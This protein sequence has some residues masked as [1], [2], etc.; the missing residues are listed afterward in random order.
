MACETKLILGT[1]NFFRPY[2]L[3]GQ[4][5]EI[6]KIIETA[7]DVGVK[8][9]DM[10]TAYIDP[11]AYPIKFIKPIGKIESLLH[12][13]NRDRELA[14]GFIKIHERQWDG[15]SVDTAAE[16]VKAAKMKMKCIEFPYNVF[17]HDKAKLFKL[18]RKRKITTIARSVF[19]QG[20]LLMDDPPI[21]LEYVKRFEHII[22]PY[23]ISK[24]EAAFLF[25]YCHGGINYVVVGVNTVEQLK[26]LSH[27]T[28]YRLPTSLIENLI[29]LDDVPEEIKYPWRWSVKHE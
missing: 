20:L 4:A 15:A 3:N 28:Q 7:V 11:Y 13:E 23:G 21:G 8:F 29:D 14:H 10:S 24:K 6:D 17:D 18:A 26:E 9:V 25:T 5:K 19:L 27:L 12:Y 1:A 16:A 2:G 22:K